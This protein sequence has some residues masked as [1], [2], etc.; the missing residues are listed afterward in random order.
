MVH[1]QALSM[2]QKYTTFTVTWTGFC[3]AFLKFCCISYTP[4]STKAR[5]GIFTHPDTVFHTS[6]TGT[7]AS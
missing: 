7:R 5:A 2:I 1:M 4:I 6:T 3:I